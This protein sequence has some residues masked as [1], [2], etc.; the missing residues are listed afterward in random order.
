M[1]E[2]RYFHSNNNQLKIKLMLQLKSI[3]KLYWNTNFIVAS[4]FDSE[5]ERLSR[6]RSCRVLCEWRVPSNIPGKGKC[7][8][9]EH[10]S[11]GSLCQPL[12]SDSWIITGS[13]YVKNIEHL[14]KVKGRLNCVLLSREEKENEG[15]F[16][17]NLT[18]TRYFMYVCGN[19][20]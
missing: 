7:W 3:P 14:L 12:L 19:K 9:E 11:P 20:V 8:R 1:H 15:L 13:K 2:V 5:R 4:N 16:I 10:R 18:R 17:H 6:E